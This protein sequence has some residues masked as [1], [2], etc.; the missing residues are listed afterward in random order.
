[1]G[2][3]GSKRG[4]AA[5][6]DT[7]GSEHVSPR[8]IQPGWAIKQRLIRLF[9]QPCTSGPLCLDRVFIVVWP[10]ELKRP[11]MA[12][13]WLNYEWIR[14]ATPEPRKEC[15]WKLCL[16]ISCWFTG[17]GV[18][19]VLDNG[20]LTCVVF[21]VLYCEQEDMV[22]GWDKKKSKYKH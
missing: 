15:A 17:T 20:L 18:Q 10:L 3:V 6:L 22:F 5:Q 16:D 21:G 9:V 14:R 19:G 7:S 12:G 8:S 13:M 2:L 11:L 1:M 4:P